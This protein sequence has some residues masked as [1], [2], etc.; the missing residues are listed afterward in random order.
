MTNY[1]FPFSTCEKTNKIGVSQPYSA[2]FNILNCLMII[3]FLQ[4]T[5]N[6]HTFILIL[7]LLCFELFHVFSHITHIPGTIQVNIIHL[8]SYSINIALLYFFYNYTNKIPSSWFIILYLLLILFD[9]YVFCNM[10]V[11]YYI[12]TQALLFLS[13]LFYYYKLLTMNIKEN[14]NTIFI[15]VVIIIMLFINEKNNC[16]KMMSYNP[17]FPY[18][19]L[20]EITGIILFYIICITFYS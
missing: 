2:F 12:F 10:N 20:I 14:I 3:Y 7:A 5:K 6:T 1:T 19:I 18:H 8:L 4:K 9:I 17:N 13:V 15:L 11:V 16:E